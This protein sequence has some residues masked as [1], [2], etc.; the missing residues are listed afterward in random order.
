MTP[1][2]LDA[3][4]E[5]PDVRDELMRRMDETRDRRK[6]DDDTMAVRTEVV[7]K[8]RLAAGDRTM[9]PT[10]F[11]LA[12]DQHACRTHRGAANACDSVVLHQKP[13]SGAC[14]VAQ[15]R[16]RREAA[17]DQEMTRQRIANDIFVTDWYMPEAHQLLLDQNG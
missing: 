15:E 8:V 1:L 6:G 5:R 4:L 16:V 7:L 11:A 10:Q 3:I 13:C 14:P 2:T 9:S 17:R 12:M